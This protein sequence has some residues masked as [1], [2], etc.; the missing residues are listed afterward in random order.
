[1]SLDERL[2]R[3]E[4]HQG[5]SRERL[6]SLEVITEEI[7]DCLK[8]RIGPS[9]PVRVDRIERFQG[10][11]VKILWAAIVAAATAVTGAVLTFIGLK[12]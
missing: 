1:M 6:A 10:G 9:L 5:E 7:R 11:V 2:E 12:G 4:E 3:I 8:P